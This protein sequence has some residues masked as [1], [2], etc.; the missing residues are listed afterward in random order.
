M[1][2][3]YKQNSKDESSRDIPLKCIYF[4]SELFVYKNS[5][6]EDEW[7]YFP[8]EKREVLLNFLQS[9]PQP[10]KDLLIENS[11]YLYRQDDKKDRLKKIIY[12]QVPSD[13]IV[14]L[15]DD[16]KK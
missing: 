16:L 4:D 3:Q 11:E 10:D 1:M 15:D 8:Y 2:L 12:E 13:W 6:C 5:D 9:L 14:K 7:F